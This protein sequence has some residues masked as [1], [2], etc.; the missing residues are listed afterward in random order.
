MYIK[1]LPDIQDEYIQGL[2]GLGDIWAMFDLPNDSPRIY[3]GEKN[4]I[5]S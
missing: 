1:A 3:Q 4:N 5:T 2:V